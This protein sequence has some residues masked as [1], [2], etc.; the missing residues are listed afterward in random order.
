MRKSAERVAIRGQ[1]FH[2]RA[3]EEGATFARLGIDQTQQFTTETMFNR[4]GAAVSVQDAA[5]ATVRNRFAFIGHTRSLPRGAVVGG[6]YS[7]C[8]VG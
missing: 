3:F 2:I 1:P 8:W 5:E 6:S 7:L 4:A